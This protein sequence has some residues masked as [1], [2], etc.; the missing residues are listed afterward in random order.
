MP[1]FGAEQSSLRAERIVDFEIIWRYG[2][3]R[4]LLLVVGIPVGVLSGLREYRS[5]ILGAVR[6]R[7]NHLN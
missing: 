5:S 7:L 6:L 1:A 4:Y 2:W 3:L